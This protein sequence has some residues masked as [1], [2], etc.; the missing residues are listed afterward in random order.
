[1]AAC[2]AN[3]NV[4][5]V[6]KSE[7]SPGRDEAT[8][9]G[10]LAAP[11]LLW[12]PTS[13]RQEDCQHPAD[14]SESARTQSEVGVGGGVDANPFV[15]NA[16]VPGDAFQWHVDADPSEFIDSDFTEHYGRYF[17]RVGYSVQS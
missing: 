9:D 17:N 13:T 5:S 2:S 7:G 15:A 8:D 12:H 4:P 11:S 1:M 3:S 6:S 10:P 16:A 14:A